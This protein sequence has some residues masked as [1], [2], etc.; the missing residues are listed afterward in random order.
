MSIGVFSIWRSSLR[1]VL[2]VAGVLLVFLALSLRPDAANAANPPPDFA[3]VTVAQG[4]FS[5]ISMEMTPDG[6]LF[7]MTDSGLAHVI[8][9][10]QLLAT[11]LFDLRS[12]VDDLG[13][14]GLFNVALDNNF[15]QNGF[16]YIMYVADTNNAD[17]GVGETRLAR[18]TVNGD[19]A[20]NLVVLFDNFPDADVALHYGGAVEHGPDGKLY[21]TIGDH[22][23]G[24]NGQDL[25][26]LEGTILRLNT[27]GTIPTDNPFYGQLNGDLRAIYAYG[28][29]NPW[30]MEQHPTSGEIF[31]S[32]VGSDDFEELNVLQRGANYGWFEAEG[33][34]DPGDPA[35]FVDP[36]WAY[37]HSDTFPNDPFAGCAI[38]GGAFYETPN[39]TFPAEFR[40]QY[41]TGD[42]CEG[43]IVTVD[44]NT[45]AASQ[46]MD[47]FNFG[48]LDLEV[49]PI[50]GDLYFIDQTFNDDNTFPR[51]GVGKITFVGEQTEISI[52]SQPSDVSIARGG[53]ASFFVSAIGPGDLT[54]Q[55]RRNGAFIQGET[56]SR[57]TLVNVGDSD[58]GDLFSVNVYSDGQLLRSDSAVLRL[59]NNTAPV[60]TISFSGA[61]GGYR[62]GQ[63]ITFSG[64]ATDAED[65]TIPGRTLR[66]DVRLNHDDHDHPLVDGFIGR[67]STYTLPPAIET[68]TNVW[69]TLY[70][71][72]TDS[73]GT[74]TTVTQ[75][76]DPRIVTITLDSDPSGLNVSLDGNTRLAPFSFDSVVGVVREISAPASQTRNGTTYTYES[77][78]DGLGRNAVRTT[79]NSNQTWTVNYSGGGGPVPGGDC[80]VA[81]AGGG[82]VL[83]W[84]NEPGTE[85]IRNSDGW[86][87]TPAAGVTS[88]SGAGDVNDG[89]LV[90]RDGVDEVCDVDGGGPTPG[91]DCVV[92]ASG[93]GVRITWSNE[94]GNE[95]LRNASGWVA[96]PP[97]GTLSYVD[98]DGDVND[99]WL[100]RRSG[101]D[102]VCS[103]NG[104]PTPGGDCVV[105][106]AGGG[107]VLTW[108]N[109][110]GTEVI[111]N[112]DGWVTT[113]AAGVT[114]YSG[115]GDVNDGWLV[116]RDGVDEVCSTGGGVPDDVC[117]VSQAGNGVRIVWQDGPGTEVI[118]NNDGWVAT[119]TDGTLSYFD[120]NGDVDDD[121]FIRRTRA[122][123]ET[124]VVLN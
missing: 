50:N 86:V 69:I 10:D 103:T 83:T 66:W 54:Y 100:I 14:R 80:V 64:S 1:S 98:P 26:N 8:K 81:A 106:A 99:G 20:S 82:I 121:Y 107:I 25:G 75:R 56:S 57:L 35:S 84:S 11:P 27:N 34:K 4:I 72:A 31:F 88:Y 24:R 65:G 116:R 2:I 94:P 120:P 22:L 41:F 101:V 13:D 58:D 113:P 29:R 15:A 16:I 19:R 70:L 60:P 40:G 52:T 39:P 33:P 45:G 90:R 63:E 123:D 105:V 42:Y 73:D 61:D 67:T 55:W 78:S 47:G 28:V 108:S 95:V 46:F 68:S 85:V 117:S 77:W 53:D 114:S 3:E 9:N 119:P 111:R 48:L 87:T 23:L 76:I 74:S 12:Q 38:V 97:A 110:P 102:E 6:R 93:N 43:R 59:T 124:C 109:E 30:Q 115:A 49:S 18:M 92:A 5:P 21:V 17:D 118:R 96:T 79:P 51:G 7:V 37:R 112:S 62:A 44:P 91:G 36:L 32:D 89:W 122:A 104:G 71:T